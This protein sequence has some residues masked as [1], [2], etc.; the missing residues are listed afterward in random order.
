MKMT[1]RP[2]RKDSS[3]FDHGFADINVDELFFSDDPGLEYKVGQEVLALDE[4]NGNS[5]K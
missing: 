4:R 5:E 3:V 1:L 2:R